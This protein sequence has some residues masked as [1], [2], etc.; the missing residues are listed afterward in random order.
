MTLDAY[1]YHRGSRSPGTRCT[2]DLHT[3]HT[4]LLPESLEQNQ[5]VDQVMSSYIGYPHNF[6]HSGHNK[7]HMKTV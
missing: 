7:I 6:I 3:P 1:A 4:Q 5:I 2:H